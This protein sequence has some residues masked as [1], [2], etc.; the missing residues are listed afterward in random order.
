MYTFWY[1]NMPDETAGYGRF[2]DLIGNFQMLPTMFKTYKFTEL[3][4]IFSLGRNVGMKGKLLYSFIV[5]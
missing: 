2:S 4:Q 1:V 5:T 3:L